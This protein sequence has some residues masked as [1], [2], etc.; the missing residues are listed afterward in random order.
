MTQLQLRKYADYL[1]DEKVDVVRI[2]GQLKQFNRFDEMIKWLVEN[3]IRGQALI[4]FF[5]DAEG[6][7]TRGVLRGVNEIL[8]RIDNDR[9][10]KD[11]LT[12]KELV[13]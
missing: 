7:E 12:G 1:W 8:K 3:K 5:N 4:D 10:N 6:V 13:R 11:P 9:F 2:L